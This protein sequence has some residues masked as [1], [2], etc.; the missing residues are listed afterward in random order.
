MSDTTSKEALSVLA[1][2]ATEALLLQQ[3]VSVF[4]DVGWERDG[5]PLPIKREQPL[6]DGSVMQLYRPMAVLEYVQ[7]ALSGEIAAKRMRDRKAAEKSQ[8]EGAS[9]SVR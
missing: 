5:F 9:D 7:E 6:P 8:E 4:H 1:R 3:P 2:R